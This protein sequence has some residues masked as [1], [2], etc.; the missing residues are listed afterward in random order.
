MECS[1]YILRQQG[2]LPVYHDSGADSSQAYIRRPGPKEYYSHFAGIYFSSC[3]I[4][5]TIQFFLLATIN[6]R[7]FCKQWYLGFSY[8]YWITIAV[9]GFVCGV[10]YAFTPK[11][12]V[13]AIEWITFFSAFLGV[14]YLSLL[15]RKHTRRGAFHEHPPFE[16]GGLQSE[17]DARIIG[18]IIHEP[19]GYADNPSSS[20][21][22]QFSEMEM[23]RSWQRL[24]RGKRSR[25]CFG[26][27]RAFNR[28]LK[29][30]HWAFS[31]LFIVGGITLALNYRFSNP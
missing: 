24:N 6:T 1:E 21:A 30:I 17:D 31:V 11:P 22:G 5:Q 19:P 2:S 16:A 27:L 29:I 23:P 13:T 14:A 8:I 7:S 10:A 3:L 4:F 9:S 28:F 15:H 26:F 12:D 20:Q 18:T 25:F